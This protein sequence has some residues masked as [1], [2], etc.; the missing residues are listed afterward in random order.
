MVYVDV[1]DFIL[2]RPRLDS[3]STFNLFW[4]TI[5]FLF[6]YGSRTDASIKKHE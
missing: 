4:K 2:T 6:N 5:E 1:V 3:E